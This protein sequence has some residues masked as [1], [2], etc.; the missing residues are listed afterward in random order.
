MKKEKNNLDEILTNALDEYVNNVPNEE[1]E[2]VEFSEEHKK[3]MED[4]IRSIKSKEDKKHRMVVLR[5]VAI[6][7]L[8][9]VVVIGLF[10]PRISAWKEKIFE[11]FI[12]DKGEYEWVSYGNSE[13]KNLDTNDDRFYTDMVNSIFG[14]IPEGYLRTDGELTPR[15]IKIKFEENSTYFELKIYKNANSGIDKENTQ[16]KIIELNDFEVE[17][18]SKYDIDT[19][20][21][22]KEEYV[23]YLRGNLNEEEMIKIIKN[24]KYG[25]IKNIL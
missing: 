10:T 13:G 24:I 22:N 9:V 17:Y 19:Y 25:E 7:L 4:L 6:I 18:N 16:E 11:F 2:K 12:K 1:Y 15:V 20:T 8:G 5:R 23:Y 21:W 3:K 14:Y